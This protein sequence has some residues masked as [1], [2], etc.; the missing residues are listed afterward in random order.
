MSNSLQR[1][2]LQ[3]FP[4]QSNR[5]FFPLIACVLPSDKTGPYN[6]GIDPTTVSGYHKFEGPDPA[7]W[8]NRGYAVINNDA[9]GSF[10]SEGHMM[11]WGPQVSY[12]RKAIPSHGQTSFTR[13]TAST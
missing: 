11:R 2:Q 5:A 9:R 10:D 1:Y 7:E 8:T 3:D 6:C 4:K 12:S 13:H